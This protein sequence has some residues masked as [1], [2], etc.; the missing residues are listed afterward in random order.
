VRARGG[1]IGIAWKGEYA[2][3]IELTTY[4]KDG[5]STF[6]WRVEIGGSDYDIRVLKEALEREREDEPPAKLLE[7]ASGTGWWWSKQAKAK[8]HRTRMELSPSSCALAAAMSDPEFG[9]RAVGE[10]LRGWGFF[11]PTPAMLR[12]PTSEIGAEGLDRFGR[13]IAARLY[14]LHKG[15]PEAFERICDATRSILGIP[16]TLEPRVSDVGNAYFVQSEPGLMHRVHQLS[17]SSGTLRMLAFMAALYGDEA[18]GLVGI[19]EPENHVHPAALKAFADH[20]REA[21]TRVQVVITTHSPLLLNCFDDPKDVRIVRRTSDGTQ[22]GEEAN[23]TGVEHALEES[24]FG[25]GE[26]YETSGFGA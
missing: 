11:D 16:E 2:S 5:N 25:L 26:F 15:R 13:N 17:V 4:V 20:L 18:A 21:S 14:A 7:A 12:Q 19:E 8:D 3:T 1:L 6:S 9:G 24:G 22:V 23:P 10:F